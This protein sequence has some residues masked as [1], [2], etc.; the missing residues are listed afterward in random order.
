MHDSRC[1][2]LFLGPSPGDTVNRPE[3]SWY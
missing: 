2:Y 1:Y 3:G